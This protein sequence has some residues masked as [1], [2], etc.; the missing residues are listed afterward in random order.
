MT[1]GEKNG[2]PPP[3][4]DA[5]ELTELLLAKIELEFKSV[6]ERVGINADKIRQLEQHQQLGLKEE[7]ASDE[8]KK[9]WR[10]IGSGEVTAGPASEEDVFMLP[11]DVYSFLAT[12]SFTSSTFW[13]A[14]IVVFGLQITLLL[15]LLANQTDFESENPLNLHENVEISVRVSQVLLLFIAM[16]QQ[17]DLLVGIVTLVRGVPTVFLGNTRFKNMSSMQWNMAHLIRVLTGILGLLVAFVLSI[18]A[19]NV[20]EV[21]LR[22]VGVKSIFKLDN[23]AFSLGS[24]G[25]FG[26]FVKRACENVREATFHR[27]KKHQ[28]WIKRV[29]H[30]IIAVS[31]LIATFTGLMF[32]FARQDS[33]FLSVRE[34]KVQFDDGIVPFLGLFSGCY[35]AVENWELG[36]R[37]LFYA[38]DGFPQGGKFGFCSNFPYGESGWTFFVGEFRN[39]CESYLLRSGDTVTF[40]VLEAVETSEWFTAGEEA[41][42]IGN[43]EITEMKNRVDDCGQTYL[44]ASFE[45]CPMIQALGSLSLHKLIGTNVSDT[46]SANQI[47]Q[48]RERGVLNAAMSHAIYYGE[49]EMTADVYESEATVGVYDLIFFTGRRWVWTTTDHIPELGNFTSPSEITD[50]FYSP[51][52]G[53]ASGLFRLLESLLT[54][55]VER[56]DVE[57]ENKWVLFMSESVDADTA[58]PLGLDWYRPVYSDDDAD[59]ESAHFKINQKLAFPP[60]FRPLDKEEFPTCQFCDFSKNLV[61]SEDCAIIK[62]VYVI[63]DMVP[64]DPCVWI[65]LWAMEFV[66]HISTLRTI[67][68]MAEIAVAPLVLGL[69]VDKTTS[70]ILL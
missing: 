21:L 46:V 15:L 33:N 34:I 8:V 49:S 23:I 53:S 17:D 16:F 24:K 32:I 47:E 55:D 45:A 52:E 14:V 1:V 12:S 30:I 38:Q 3:P 2:D 41:E 48:I 27:E 26:R 62:Q 50:Y 10:L 19:D 35:T 37:R 65:C 57:R 22:G 5:A 29:L 68:T 25:Y 13:M 28:A 70:T 11:R 39:P 61:A 54:D 43:L 59:E 31:V 51:T 6:R 44:E 9:S 7:V 4:R 64:P 58:S 18:Q 36:N 63:V 66:I 56:G 60:P 20:L 67:T 42:P 40:S 69:L